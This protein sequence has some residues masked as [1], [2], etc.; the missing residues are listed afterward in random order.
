[1][2]ELYGH[3]QRLRLFI[4]DLRCRV[5]LYRALIVV[6][7]RGHNVIESIMIWKGI[8]RGSLIH[9]V[10]FAAE[11]M[12]AG[13]ALESLSSP[14][15]LFKRIAQLLCDPAMLSSM[16]QPALTCQ[17]LFVGAAGRTWLGIEKLLAER[18]RNT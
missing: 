16:G 4:G 18:E 8:V 12:R 9:R 5:R 3:D 11:P 6:H 2:A 13:A 1:M 7:Y 10:A 14:A 15:T 17:G